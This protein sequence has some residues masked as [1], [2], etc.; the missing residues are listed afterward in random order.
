MEIKP[1]FAPNIMASLTSAIKA[2]ITNEYPFK[3]CVNCSHFEI[4]AEHC[5]LTNPRIRPPAI[6]IAFGC[7]KYDD[8]RIPF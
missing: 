3:T 5:K 6:I 7:P 1:T 2:A 8:D 4:N